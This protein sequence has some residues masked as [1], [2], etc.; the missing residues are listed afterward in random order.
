MIVMINKHS[1]DL[2]KILISDTTIGLATGRKRTVLSLI[3]FFQSYGFL[4]SPNAKNV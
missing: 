1:Q 2:D 4:R 3:A